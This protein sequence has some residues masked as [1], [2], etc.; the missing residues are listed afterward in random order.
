MANIGLKTAADGLSGSIQFGGV[1]VVTINSGGIVN[2]P[3]GNI[4]ATTVQAAINELDTEKAALAGSA[5]QAF[6]VA[7]ATTAAHAVRLDQMLGLGQTWQ[8]LTGARA[9]STSYTNTTGKPIFVSFFGTCLQDSAA[10]LTID[11]LGIIG[12]VAYAN[13]KG[14]FVN[15]IVPPGSTYYIAADGLAI[16]Q[17]RE[18]R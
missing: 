9:V 1:D 3:A 10:T 2:T 13:T 8:N 6:S 4:A 5:S 7:A 15:G 16:F 14:T 11:G 18:L 17:W 12:S